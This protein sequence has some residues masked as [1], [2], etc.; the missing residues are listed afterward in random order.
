VEN[1]RIRPYKL[2]QHGKILTGTPFRSWQNL[3]WT[4]FPAVPVR[5]HPWPYT[6]CYLLTYLLIIVN[7]LRQF[8]GITDM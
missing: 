4:A 6:C 5:I 3:T 2:L 1:K 8:S 7:C